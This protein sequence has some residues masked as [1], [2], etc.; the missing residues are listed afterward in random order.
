MTEYLI[1]I[2]GEQFITE[3]PHVL[4]AWEIAFAQAA[5]MR[6][7]GSLPQ[8]EIEVSV[9]SLKEAERRGSPVIFPKKLD[10]LEVLKRVEEVQADFRKIR[11][12]QAT[13]ERFVGVRA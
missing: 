3:A 10:R 12:G 8:E 1:I 7:E 6:Y 11:G 5:L 2:E 13:L 4:A 9:F